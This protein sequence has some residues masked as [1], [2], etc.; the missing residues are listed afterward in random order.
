M[1]L[2]LFL[3]QTEHF[4]DATRVD[5]IILTEFLTKNQDSSGTLFDIVAFVMV[6][7]LCGDLCKRHAD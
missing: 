2:L 4:C 3:L 6:H 1:H 5:E 7:G